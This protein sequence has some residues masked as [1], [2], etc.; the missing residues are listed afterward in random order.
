MR[1]DKFKLMTY[2]NI[3]LDER[4]VVTLLYA[5]LIGG[6]AFQLY[7]TLWSLIDRS[8]LKTPEYFH[9]KLYDLLDTDPV[10]FRD[11]RKV[12]EA[13]GLI[14]VYQKDDV[15]IY[16]IKAPVSAEEFFKD[17]ALGA[18]LY[19]R[20]GQKEFEEI[21]ALFRI[22]SLEKEGFKN[23][24]AN[25]DDVFQS[26]KQTPV[27]NGNYISRSKSKLHI[28]HDFDFDVFVDGIS[29]N[30][31]DKRKLTNKVKEKIITTSYIYDLDEITM[32]KVF[33]DSVDNDRNINIDK[34]SKSAKYWN[35]IIHSQED[36]KEYQEVDITF[37]NIKQLC[38]ANTPMDIIGISTGTRPSQTELRTIEKVVSEF[39]YPLEITN[40]ILL[41][42]MNRSSGNLLPHYNFLESIYVGMKRQ[43]VK[44]FEDAYN[45]T[46][47]YQQKANEP[48]K[49]TKRT[50][51]PKGLEPDWLK[52]YKEEF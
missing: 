9:K 25:F 17:G 15:F 26:I 51:K 30:Y 31:I 35:G 7:F 1:L 37:D 27:T 11:T 36:P 44:T 43:N 2:Q 32:Q 38:K 52:E 20:I 48:K 47:T 6:N 50:E 46:I 16:E 24:T 22:S 14:S 12:L 39:D 41:Y 4:N 40:F 49:T 18:L 42:G 10:Q 13:I 21:S 45:Y 8:R 29:K 28:K 33:M 3:D 19:Q 23:V 5:P 34:M